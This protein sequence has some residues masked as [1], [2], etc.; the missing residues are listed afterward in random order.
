MIETIDQARDFRA[1][2]EE[3]A[4]YAPPEVAVKE[5]GL[6]PV[7]SPDGVD[8]YDGTDGQHPQSKVRGLTHPDRLY[9]CTTPHT[10][11]TSWEPDATPALWTAIDDTHAGTIDDPIPAVRGMEY[12]YGLY[13][14]DDEDGKT[15]L[16]ER[17]GETEGSKIILQYLPHEL[18]GQYFTEVVSQ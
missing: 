17:I 3:A 6:Y 13:Y 18:V 10:S 16:C 9:K 5:P 7:W 12:Q 15:Y 4:A 1:K 11:Q 2:M 8:Y 14:L